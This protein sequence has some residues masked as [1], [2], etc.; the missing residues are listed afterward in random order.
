M[1]NPMN[2][3]VSLF[4]PNLC[5]LCGHPLVQNE[6]F[7]C[8]HC[9]CNLPKTNYHFNKGNQVHDLFAGFPNVNEATGFLFFEKEGITQKLIHSLKY[10]GHKTLATFLGRIAALELKK[11]GL[12]ASIDT[13]VPIPLHPKKE[14]RRGYNQSEWIAKGIA[15]VYGCN[16]DTQLLKRTANTQSQ[17]RKSVYDRHVNVEKIFT[18]TNPEPISGKHILLIDDVITTG[19]TVS[20]CIEALM[21][22]P[23]LMISIFSL[24]V[25]REY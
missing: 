17:T 3:L 22:V 9:H 12:F 14:K 8:L 16:I 11:D 13:I 15:S 23:D 1:I 21:P 7:I 19:A 5:L 4:Y 10:Y 24:S 25:T 18:L 2:E 6:Q 20:S